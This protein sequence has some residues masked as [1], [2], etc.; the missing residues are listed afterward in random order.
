LREFLLV[1]SPLLRSSFT[2]PD[3]NK[4]IERNYVHGKPSPQLETQ[5]IPTRELRELVGEKSGGAF[6]AFTDPNKG[7]ERVTAP[8][9][10]AVHPRRM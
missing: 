1:H 3:P 9:T 2:K 4:G 10:A 5:L 8:R 6:I 7:I